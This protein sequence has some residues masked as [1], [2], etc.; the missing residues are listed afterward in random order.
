VSRNLEKHAFFKNS[1]FSETKNM[2]VGRILDSYTTDGALSNVRLQFSS[3]WLLFFSIFYCKPYNTSAIHPYYLLRKT[4][5]SVL[6]TYFYYCTS[7][8]SNQMVHQ[9]L[10]WIIQRWRLLF[11]IIVPL[12]LLPLPIIHDTLVSFRILYKFFLNTFLLAS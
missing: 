10:T 7:F 3:Y 12:G 6:K 4:I 8:W 1:I 5:S 11:V 2:T 9:I